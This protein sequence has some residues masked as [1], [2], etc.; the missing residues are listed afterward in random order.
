MYFHLKTGEKYQ[1][2]LL[3]FTG[4]KDGFRNG[5]VYCTLRRRNNSAPIF[6]IIFYFKIALGR[7]IVSKPK[8]K[9]GNYYEL[10]LDENKKIKFGVMYGFDSG[11]NKDVYAL[12]MYTKDKIFE[13]PVSK[14]LFEEWINDG[15]I[16]EITYHDVLTDIIWRILIGCVVYEN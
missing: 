9:V 6:D 13:F 3:V 2:F 15:R 1:L 11:K 4:K 7:I 14:K 10:R 5:I 12:M 16:S 8:L